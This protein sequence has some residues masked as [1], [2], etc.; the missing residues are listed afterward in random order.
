[1]SLYQ[2]WVADIFTNWFHLSRGSNDNWDNVYR[3]EVIG[4]CHVIFQ[5]LV[6]NHLFPLLSSHSVVVWYTDVND[7]PFSRAFIH[8]NYI[9]SYCT[10]SDMSRCWYNGIVR[11]P[12]FL[13]LQKRL[14][15]MLPGYVG[16]LKAVFQ[17]EPPMDHPAVV[18][19][20]RRVPPPWQQFWIV[21]EEM[22]NIFDAILSKSALVICCQFEDFLEPIREE[23]FVLCCKN[24]PF[25][26]II[27]D[28]TF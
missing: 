14:R 10:I 21:G 9:W 12:G 7:V 1:M 3:L 6:F 23:T 22:V 16:G 28:S 25:I 15:V 2:G 20:P 17:A 4:V 8:D 27:H 13:V 19:M 11:Y 24:N 26:V 5:I 18:V